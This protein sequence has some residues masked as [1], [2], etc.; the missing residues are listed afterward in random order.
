[1]LVSK[2]F[3]YSPFQFES[4]AFFVSLSHDEV[5]LPSPSDIETV[6]ATADAMSRVLE[7]LLIIEKVK[8]GLIHPDQVAT[9]LQPWIPTQTPQSNA[10]SP[11]PT[12]PSTVPG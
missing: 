10:S 3:K 8:L 2:E 1:M 5:G 4:K 9:Q 6:R 12:S 11:A 7:G